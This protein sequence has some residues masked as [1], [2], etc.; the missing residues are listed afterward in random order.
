[1]RESNNASS[2]F[3]VAKETI[4]RSPAV[5]SRFK[6]TPEQ[7]VEWMQQHRNSYLGA[8]PKE[9]NGRLVGRYIVPN[10]YSNMLY[11]GNSPEVL[12]AN[13][14]K[15]ADEIRAGIRGEAPLHPTMHGILT[16]SIQKQLTQQ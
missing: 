6:L 5:D 12:E 2:L 15:I 11:E 9:E 10:D 14:R 16:G 4:T 8:P 7:A 3:Q 1:M 13:K